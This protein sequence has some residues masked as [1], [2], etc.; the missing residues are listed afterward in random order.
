MHTFT[1]QDPT[2]PHVFIGNED[3]AFEAYAADEN[4]QHECMT[5]FEWCVA[6]LE[7][8]ILYV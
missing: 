3:L 4:A 6:N 8:V 5:W 2:G 1:I 7:Q